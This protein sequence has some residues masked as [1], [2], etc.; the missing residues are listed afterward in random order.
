MIDDDVLWLCHAYNRRLGWSMIVPKTAV[1][2][3]L[4]IVRY[5]W[6]PLQTTL[7]K[8]VNPYERTSFPSYLASLAIT[9]L[10]EIILAC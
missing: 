8:V 10:P 6:I 9:A 2:S 4:I 1:T 7:S 3:L 5:I